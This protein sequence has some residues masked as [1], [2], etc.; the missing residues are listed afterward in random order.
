[1]RKKLACYWMLACLLTM[2]AM[3]IAVEE[4]T[5]SLA[6]PDAVDNQ[7]ASD[8]AVER[9]LYESELLK[10]Y[11]DWQA[12]VKEDHGFSFGADYSTVS[13]YGTDSLPDSA[14]NASGGIARFYGSW[15]ILGRGTD[16]T[17]TLTYKVE[18]RHRYGSTPPSAFGMGNVGTVGMFEPPFS[19]QGW[20]LT[21]LYWN[22]Q[23][24][25]GQIIL[26]GGFLDATDFVDVFGLASPWLHFMN[27]AFSTGSA[28][29][30]LPNDAAL[31]M[32][33]GFW[34]SDQ[35]YILAGLE[36]T[37][38]DPTDA[39]DGFDTFFSDHEYFK[40][41]EFGWTTASDR[42]YFDNLHVT[43]WQADERT[44]AATPDGWGVVGSYTRYIDNTYMPFLRAGYA[45]D[46]GS[47]LQ[48]SVSAGLGYQPQTGQGA[49]RDLLGAGVNWGQPNE[50]VFG[51]NLKDQY[52]A[53]LFYRLQL[54]KEIA[55][56]P[57]IQWIIDPAL[58][59]N[60]DSIVVAGLRA[61]AAF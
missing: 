57:D 37:N 55:V 2:Q 13:L 25:N 15:A 12:Q 36:D 28:S 9:G 40:H 41:L 20:R 22:Q 33:G 29:I 53:E 50:T 56:T 11:F 21:N 59:T 39:G 42:V 38:S 46:G 18:H 23:R 30:S 4:H 48:N 10:P 44:V 35:V 7:M 32:A 34:I 51:P 1:M 6:G 26:L 61:R 31:G 45:E 49:G 8:Q 17:G 24:N 47:F 14:D 19:N 5:P 58:N 3:G 54:T 52:T 27:F 43:L 60:D 16:N